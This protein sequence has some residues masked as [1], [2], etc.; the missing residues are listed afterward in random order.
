M[1]RMRAKVSARCIARELTVCLRI[2]PD[3]VARV[4][5]KGV[6]ETSSTVRSAR[7]SNPTP[8]AVHP[9]LR[10]DMV[11]G[12]TERFERGTTVSHK[13]RLACEIYSSAGKT[14]ERPSLSCLGPTV[15]SDLKTSFTAASV[16]RLQ[17]SFRRKTLL[18]VRLSD[19]SRF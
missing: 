19:R 12:C 10:A 13:K 2:L 18:G 3:V 8:V 15:S 16:R 11:W 4:R 6:V 7:V 5:G 14:S 9:S 17:T 1:E